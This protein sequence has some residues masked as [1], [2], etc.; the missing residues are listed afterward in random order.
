ME[1][2]EGTHILMDSSQIHY[3][4]ATV[5]TPAN[6]SFFF[7]GHT[8]A[9]GVSQACGLIGTTAAGLHHSHS[10]VKSELRLWPMPQLIATA[11]P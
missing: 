8:A 9:H 3:H 1:A 10:N 2:R 4:R 5:G 6:I 7:L 11:D